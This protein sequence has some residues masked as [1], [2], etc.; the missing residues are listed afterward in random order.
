MPD[1]DRFERALG[2]GA[3]PGDPAL[4]ELV[5]AMRAASS[6]APAA[7]PAVAS[8][9]AHG[10][11]PAPLP[12]ARSWRS[13]VRRLL[14]AIAG[15]G[16]AGKI[17][18]AVGVAFAATAAVVGIHSATAPSRASLPTPTTLAPGGPGQ[19]TTP[20]TATTPLA[21]STTTMSGP[22]PSTSTTATAPLAQSTT[23]TSTTSTPPPHATTTTRPGAASTP[24]THP[25]PTTAAPDTT[26]TAAPAT[27][28]TT[29]EA[30]APVD[31]TLT[32]T[33]AAPGPG[34]QCTW[35]APPAG[36]AQLALARSDG[37]GFY[38]A[39]TARAYTDTSVHSGVAYTYVIDALSAGGKVIGHSNHVSVTGN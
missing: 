29:T 26:T 34:V 8:F 31:M 20:T 36:S 19:G 17:G 13:R 21:P 25:T 22:S 39:A 28:T 32:C 11:G 7:S 37:H 18:L 3:G 15:L 23:T 1:D 16:T 10:H 2:G 5:G 14:R 24:T 4:D 6:R 35:S 38:L 30:H 9:L 27:T 33:P 12:A